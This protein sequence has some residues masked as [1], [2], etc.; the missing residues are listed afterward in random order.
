MSKIE[1]TT[2]DGKYHTVFD[3]GKMTVSRHGQPWCDITGNGYILSLVQR[4]NGLQPTW[5]K[6]S[7]PPLLDRG[8]D[9]KVWGLVDVNYY[10]ISYDG[11]RPD[12]K[13]NMVFTLRE[14]VRKVVELRFSNTLATDD[15]LEHYE[16]YNTFPDSAP[17]WLDDWLSEDGDFLGLHGFYRRGYEEGG[18]YYSEF[19]SDM[20]ITDFQDKPTMKLIA[21]SEFIVPEVPNVDDNLFNRS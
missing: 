21:W 16:E 19:N 10:D 1:I 9:I 8:Q 11:V 13:A 12:G 20:V 18:F 3:N 4:I 15:E 17:G 14:T 6:P 5:R 7:D 2:D